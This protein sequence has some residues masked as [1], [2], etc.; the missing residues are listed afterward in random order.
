MTRSL[1]V[2]HSCNSRSGDEDVARSALRASVHTLCII[3]GLL[4]IGLLGLAGPAAAQSSAPSS[5]SVPEEEQAATDE[6]TALPTRRP[7]GAAL[8]HVVGESTFLYNR[9][10]S[11]APVRRLPVR[12][13]LHRQECEEGWC[14]VRT[15]DGR[16]GHVP[17]DAVSNVWIRVSKAERRVYLYRGPVLDTTFKAD[18]GYNTFSD[19]KRQ[20]SEARRDHWRTPEGVFYI[21]RKNPSSS[22]YKALVLNYPTIDD[23]ERGRQND[24][25][26]EAEHDAIVDAQ[27]N[28]EMPPMDTD[29]GGWIEIH[30][31]GTGAATTWTEGCVA[32]RNQ[33]MDRLWASVPVGTPVLV[34]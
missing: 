4:L 15:D 5:V 7:D 25:I 21:V 3:G 34:E 10:D 9:P 19:K 24:L 33:D 23:A 8:M 20:G 1:P 16:T 26:S 30:G 18:V 32:V 27:R 28:F 17:E 14:R 13:P 12:A 11:T 29:L 6:R 22:F 2:S 31:E